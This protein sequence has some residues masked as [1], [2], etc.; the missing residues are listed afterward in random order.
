MYARIAKMN[1]LVGS[2]LLVIASL[3]LGVSTQAATV[4]IALCAKIGSVTMPDGVSVDVWGFAWK[5]TGPPDVPCSDSSVNAGLPGPVLNVNAGDSVNVI[6]YNELGENVS[7]LFPGQTLPPDTIGVAPGGNKT[8]SFTASN[9]GTYLYESGTNPQVQVPMGLYGA[10]IVR[11][12]T[13]GQAYNTAAS[14]YNVEATLVLSE[15]DPAQHAN[16]TGF[17]LLNYAP[18]YWLINGKAYPDTDPITASAGDRVLLRY[19]N[20]GSLHHTMALL[21]AH[22][23]VIARDAYPVSY[24]YEVVAETIASGQTT[25]TIVSPCA[26][27]SFSVFESNLHLTNGPLSSSEHFPGGMLTFIT[28]SFAACAGGG[29]H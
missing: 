28:G 20:A 25:D 27:T 4:S 1:G 12:A 21:G 13:P 7:L 16:P 11:P 18:T 3:L 17:N 19:L 5:P 15:I 22:Q 23:Q 14:A 2:G 9:P 29:R 10:L 8:Y 26:G 24:P 6:L